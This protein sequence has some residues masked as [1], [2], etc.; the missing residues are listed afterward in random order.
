VRVGYASFLTLEFG[1]PVWEKLGNSDEEYAHGEWHLWIQH[2]LWRLEH[3]GAVVA[4]S[5]DDRSS[6]ERAVGVLEGRTLA[7]VRVEPATLDTAFVF[8]GGSS[9]APAPATATSRR[10][11]RPS[12]ARG[13]GPPRRRGSRSGSSATPSRR[14]R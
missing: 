13:T 2:A 10:T 9:S 6:L 12:A 8:D 14:P 7:D 3:G 4:A 5:D 11:R 1:E